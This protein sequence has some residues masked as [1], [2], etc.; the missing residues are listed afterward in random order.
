MCI[1]ADL[2][3]YHPPLQ[4]RRRAWRLFSNTGGRLGSLNQPHR[5]RRGWNRDHN[6]HPIATTTYSGMSPLFHP[7]GFFC[8]E[9]RSDAQAVKRAHR[10]H[11]GEE[12][13][14]LPVLV[15]DIVAAGRTHWFFGDVIKTPVLVC[16]SIKIPTEAR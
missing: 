7:A 4:G 14:L 3:I 9:H 1:A 11:N 10:R 13:V 15:R 16:R 12:L 5:F 6:D 2:K 8:F